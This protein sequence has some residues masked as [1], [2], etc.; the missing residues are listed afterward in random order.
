[1]SAPKKRKRDEVV[2][3]PVGNKVMGESLRQEVVKYISGLSPQRARPTEAW[4]D[5]M[6]ACAN[7]ACIYT[8][9]EGST[10]VFMLG[11]AH[12]F[13]AK[14][15][16]LYNRASVNEVFWQQ[17]ARFKANPNRTHS[18]VRSL[19]DAYYE[20][21]GEPIAPI[22]VA[23]PVG[24]S[25]LAPQRDLLWLMKLFQFPTK[26]YVITQYGTTRAKLESYVQVEYLTLRASNS[27]ICHM[28]KG[29]HTDRI[30]IN[31]HLNGRSYKL[32][33]AYYGNADAPVKCAKTFAIGDE[34][35]AEYTAAF[36]EKPQLA[37][38][39]A[40]G[41]A[42]A[43]AEAGVSISHT[44][45]AGCVTPPRGGICSGPSSAR[46]FRR[47][48]RA[49]DCYNDLHDTRLSFVCR[50][51]RGAAAFS[52]RG[53]RFLCYP[54]LRCF[55]GFEVLETSTRSLRGP[56]L[57]VILCFLC[58]SCVCQDVGGENCPSN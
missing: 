47:I 8:F 27:Y 44:S 53:W 58:S 1:M 7:I 35:L 20:D 30:R 18:S 26:P 22:K 16:E 52:D 40:V 42:A 21:G 54:T 12:A 32:K 2:V 55:Q 3:A 25:L 41:V 28:C 45:A 5:I 57:S 29:T 43:C 14:G 50:V 36:L 19:E 31:I 38:E 24:P 6:W 46:S 37:P 17:V 10:A 4:L 23:Q 15:E 48:L 34:A 49:M 56:P 11:L 39:D 9:D 51:K 13:S 33:A